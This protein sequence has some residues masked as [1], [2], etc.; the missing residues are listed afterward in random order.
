MRLEE[1]V[2]TSASIGETSSRRTKIEL[3]AECLRRLGPEEVPIAVAFL[4]GGLPQG[5]IGVGWASLRDRP[6][7]G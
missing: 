3:I 4:S 6:T 5:T 2:T 7:C 1:I